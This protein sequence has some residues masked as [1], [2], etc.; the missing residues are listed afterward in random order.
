MKYKYYLV[1][2][3]KPDHLTLSN[4]VKLIG[5]FDN[6]SGKF[7]HLNG[8]DFKQPKSICQFCSGKNDDWS[9]YIISY[10]GGDIKF[11][12]Q[13]CLQDEF[14]VSPFKITKASDFVYNF[15]KIINIIEK[16]SIAPTGI[17]ASN[18]KEKINPD[19]VLNF[20]HDFIS[21]NGYE[22]K[23]VLPSG[24]VKNKN[25][26]TESKV[27]NKITNNI[28][29]QKFWS[30]ISDDKSLREEL[31]IFLS[32][33]KSTDNL[34]YVKSVLS[35]GG[36]FT[37]RSLNSIIYVFLKF[38]ES[39]NSIQMDYIANVGETINNI[40]VEVVSKAKKR[41]ENYGN[42]LNYIGLKTSDGRTL[43]YVGTKFGELKIGSKWILERAN[44]SRNYFDEKRQQKLS[45]ISLVHMK[46]A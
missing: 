42:L 34:E 28:L 14:G 46:E 15:S 29:N 31:L 7:K 2:I 11:I 12:G 8:S 16:S 6:N 10:D 26:N 39:K 20:L 43:L 17:K 38:I 4:N 45:V 27:K 33:F 32:R 41:G 18:Y 23:I 3:Q 44:I 1:D 13:N 24:E 21:K 37:L 40:P 25:T 9:D 30:T 35:S 19:K 22:K 5:I 36:E